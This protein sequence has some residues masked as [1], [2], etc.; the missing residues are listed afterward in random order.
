MKLVASDK[1][2][3]KSKESENVLSLSFLT[4]VNFSDGE[5][6]RSKRQAVMLVGGPSK[7]ELEHMG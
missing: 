5:A 3:E 4:L 7:G 1:L 2:S 6:R